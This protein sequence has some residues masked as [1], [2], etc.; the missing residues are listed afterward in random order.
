MSYHRRPGRAA[1]PF[2]V[3][4]KAGLGGFLD[5]LSAGFGLPTSSS[6]PA[7]PSAT[8]TPATADQATKERVGCTPIEIVA[9]PGTSPYIACKTKLETAY[10]KTQSTSTEI[11]KLLGAL[12][13]NATKPAPQPVVVQRAG[14]ISPVTIALGGAAAL[15]LLYFATKD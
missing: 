2:R 6:T 3:S 14:G 7:A 4:K 12:A 15:T 1:R 13:A 11:G 8:W 5:S 10:G 9:S